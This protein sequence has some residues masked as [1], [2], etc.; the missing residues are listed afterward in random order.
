MPGKITEKKKKSKRLIA[1]FLRRMGKLCF[2]SYS[3]VLFPQI[4]CKEHIFL[5]KGKL[6][7]LKNDF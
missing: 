7:F 5:Y 3:S 1:V 4:L 6:I 2:P